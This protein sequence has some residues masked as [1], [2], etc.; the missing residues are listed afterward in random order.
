MRYVV[1]RRAVESLLKNSPDRIEKLLVAGDPPQ[2]LPK[3]LKVERLNLKDFIGLNHQGLVALVTPTPFIRLSEI[4]DGPVV[5]LD[6]ILD[7]QNVGAILRTASCFGVKA[8]VWSKNRS[9]GVTPAVSKVSAGGSELVPICPVSNLAQA[10]KK[11]K[12]R[13]FWVVVSSMDGKDLREVKVPN[14]FVL[15]VG[16]EDQGIS[17]LVEDIADYNLTISTDPSGVESLNV[18][19]AAAV[20]LY[21]LTWL[22]L[23]SKVP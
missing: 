22:S 2:N 6:G 4:S 15:V 13:G 14:P 10:L 7:P 19:A 3:N 12:D 21:E 1:G 11:L 5:A 20:L 18:S 8:V 9:P 17:R 16:S 23:R